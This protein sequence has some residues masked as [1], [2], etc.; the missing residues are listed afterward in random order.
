MMVAVVQNSAFEETQ[1]YEII[2]SNQECCTCNAQRQFLKLQS[3]KR[4][5]F[6]SYLSSSDSNCILCVWVCP[7][8]ILASA[9]AL[10]GLL[11]AL[12]GLKHLGLWFCRPLV[13]EVL[14]CWACILTETPLLL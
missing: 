10:L 6:L 3:L 1:P 7:L 13:C 12:M 11:E 2:F 14:Q 8:H 5:E 9:R 4:G